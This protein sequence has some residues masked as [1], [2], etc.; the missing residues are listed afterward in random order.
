MKKVLLN[1]ILLLCA[2]IVGT[3]AWADITTTL[4][5][6]NLGVK[7]GTT[8]SDT[9]RTPTVD[10]VSY[11]LNNMCSPSTGDH[12]GEIQSK[13]SDGIIYNTSA[14]P[15]KIV[16][17]SVTATGTARSSTFYY[18]TDGTNW[19]SIGAKSGT[20]TIDYSSYNAQ[21][22]KIVR[23]SNAAYWTQIQV[24]YASSLTKQDIDIS[25]STNYEWLGTSSG[26]NLPAANCPK[27]IDCS[28]V[29]AIVNGSGTYPRGDASYI[30]MYQNST[31]QL[32]APTGYYIEGVVFTQSTASGTKW[33]ADPSAN[34]GTYTAST[35]SWAGENKTSVT[36]TFS[37]QCWISDI[38]ITLAYNLSL[39]GGKFKSFCPIEDVTVPAN[40]TV[41]RGEVVGSYIVLNSVDIN[42]IKKGEGVLLKAESNTN[43]VFSMTTGADDIEDNELK[44][45]WQRTDRNETKSTYA[46]YNE[47]NG[48]QV[49]KLYTGAKLPAN[50]AFFELDAQVSAPSVI[51]IVDE[52]NGATDIKAVEGNDNTVKFFNNG[53]LYIKRDG[54]TYDL[55]GRIV[56]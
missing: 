10:G 27:Y 49:F 21:Y 15:G 39:T 51:R 33:A 12:T 8:Y 46:L 48:D 55:M 30:R 44:G 42:K 47:D 28:G 6:T 18:S 29:S 40:V 43:A 54:V 41:Y 4:N 22:F 37:A 7:S 26:G 16:S 25:I 45:V 34:V 24:T 35:K 38:E 32:T 19:T 50:K 53:M 9:E 3:N 23:G 2:L 17:V 1:S 52:E 14:F 20:Q 36:F 56:K 31:L 13:A 5:A 11:Y